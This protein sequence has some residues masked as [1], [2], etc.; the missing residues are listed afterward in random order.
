MVLSQSRGW[1][2]AYKRGSQNQSLCLFNKS[3]RESNS[4][5]CILWIL[6]CKHI[7]LDFSLLCYFFGTLGFVVHWNVYF[8]TVN[9]VHL[10]QKSC[11]GVSIIII[12]F[13]IFYGHLLHTS[14]SELVVLALPQWQTLFQAFKQK[15]IKKKN[16]NSYPCFGLQKKRHPCSTLF[17]ELKKFTCSKATFHVLES[18]VFDVEL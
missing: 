17:W 12:I 1:T 13:N 16:V 18:L 4:N 14:P 15:P 7:R 5:T 10:A 11:C 6:T 9:K 2:L 8:S 3:K